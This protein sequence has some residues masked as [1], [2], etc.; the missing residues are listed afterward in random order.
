[1][2]QLTIMIILLDI[3]F[4]VFLWQLPN[5]LKVQELV[6]GAEYPKV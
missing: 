3:H 4:S 2:M 1:M 5:S 6:C